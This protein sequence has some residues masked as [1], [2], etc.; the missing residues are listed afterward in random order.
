MLE[1]ENGD[2]GTTLRL[3]VNALNRTP[4]CQIHFT[5][6][7]RG[8][9]EYQGSPCWASPT[10]GP[11]SHARSQG[12]SPSSTFPWD[13]RSLSWPWLSD[14]RDSGSAPC[15]SLC[16]VKA[17][18]AS[19][20]AQKVPC[21]PQWGCWSSDS[22]HGLGPQGQQTCP[23]GALGNWLGASSPWTDLHF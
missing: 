10:G 15:F 14:S 6:V 22:S 20:R 16:P 7:K 17:H 18:A 3:D 2:G 4:V 23:D 11:P 1:T 21:P 8:V 13:P 5:T 9:L 12:S 19:S